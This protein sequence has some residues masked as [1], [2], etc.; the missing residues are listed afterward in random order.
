MMLDRASA[1][2]QTQVKLLARNMLL[3][4]L[5][6]GLPL[7]VALVTTPYVLRGLGVELFGLLSLARGA[8]NYFALAEVGLGRATTRYVAEAFGESQTHRIP[9]LVWTS[10]FTQ[11]LLGAAHMAVR[12]LVSLR[13]NEL[14][15]KCYSFRLSCRL[16]A[17]EPAFRILPT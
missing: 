14:A 9:R 3:S 12:D 6:Q 2:T 7:A 15:T 4:L 10:L 8:L 16:T 11:L 17:R 13:R 5:T 1:A